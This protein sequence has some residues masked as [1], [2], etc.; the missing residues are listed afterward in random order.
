MIGDMQEIPVGGQQ[1]VSMLDAG[2]RDQAVDGTKLDAP[3]P[4]KLP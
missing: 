2:R 4:A 1:G 3:G